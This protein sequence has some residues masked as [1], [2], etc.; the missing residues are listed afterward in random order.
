M[1][2]F[3]ASALGFPVRQFPRELSMSPEGLAPCNLTT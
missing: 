1:S 2:V 3:F